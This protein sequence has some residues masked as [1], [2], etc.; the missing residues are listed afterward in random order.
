MRLE[1]TN[2]YALI[3]F[4]DDSPSFLSHKKLWRSFQETQKSKSISTE[5]IFTAG[6]DTF[7]DWKNEASKCCD[8]PFDLLMVKRDQQN[9]LKGGII[10]VLFQVKEK[11]SKNGIENVFPAVRTKET[12][13][14]S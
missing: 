1:S 7:S 11:S 4:T 9:R 6:A 14:H 3:G 8:I 12:S 10:S 13:F 2:M 5:N